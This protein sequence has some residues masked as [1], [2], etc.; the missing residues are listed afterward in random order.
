MKRKRK[1][2]R[3]QRRQFIKRFVRPSRERLVVLKF[4]RLTEKRHD[5]KH[6]RLARKQLGCQPQRRGC[7]ADSSTDSGRRE[8]RST[9]AFAN[10]ACPFW[11]RGNRNRHFAESTGRQDIGAICRVAANSHRRVGLSRQRALLATGL[12]TSCRARSA[13]DRQTTHSHARP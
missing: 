10:E 3:K 12:T 13:T 4:R 2:K 7:R 1:R 8:K 9:I 11:C 6:R 5:Q